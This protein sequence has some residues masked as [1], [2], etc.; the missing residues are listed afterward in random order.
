MTDKILVVNAG[1][2]YPIKAM[3]QMRTHNMISTLSKDFRIDLLTPS[4]NDESLNASYKAMHNVDGEYIP[5]TSARHEKNILKKRAS[6][7]LKYFSY[8]ICGIDKEV[9][10][11]RR[12]NKWIIKIIKERNY[13]IV[14]SNYWEASLYFRDLSAEV[15]KILDPHYAVGENIN[16]LDSIK[17]RRIKYYL[18]K[19]KLRNNLKM[20]REVIAVSDLLLPLSVRNQE[21]FYKIAPE[22]PMLLVA[23]GADLDYYLTYP[24]EPDPRTIL[25]Y[26]ALGSAQNKRAFQRF[27]ENIYPHIK[28]EFTDIRLLVVGSGPP[29]EIKALHDGEKII[30]TGFVK[31][32]RPW[33]SKAWLKVIPLEL[34]SGFRGRVIELMAMGVP[35][36]GTHN[37]L[38]SIGLENGKEGFISDSNQKLI[39][40]SLEILKS[41]QLRNSISESARGFVQK[42]YTLESTFGKLR[43]YLSENALCD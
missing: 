24:L 40:M 2:V 17:S 18:A 29:E 22:K 14:I 32:V 13:R 36:L 3:N 27:Y 11:N 39:E 4:N 10:V 38:D 33:L 30:V 34:G 28:A 15:F 23:D 20:E 31:D 12:N 6:Q 1:P 19:R 7:L 42:H 43:N 37:A 21:E 35:V 9:T 8:L 5:I 16:V 25:F 26:G 41:T